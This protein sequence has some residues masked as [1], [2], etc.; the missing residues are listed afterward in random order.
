MH[1]LAE[2]LGL[3]HTSEGDGRGR[4]IR[5]EK[6]PPPP[7]NGEGH[8]LVSESDQSAAAAEAAPVVAMTAEEMR[9][10]RLAAL[11]KRA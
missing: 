9:A 1:S 6:K 2:E 11:E 5:V 3:L 8:R 10:A 4:Y 7:F